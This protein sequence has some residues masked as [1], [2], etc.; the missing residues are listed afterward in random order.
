MK[1]TKSRVMCPD[2]RRQKMLFETEKE[3]KTFLKFN[4]EAVNPDGTREMR[5]YYCPACCGYH[6]SSHKFVG[7]NRRTDRMIEK[8]REE[9][10]GGIGAATELYEKLEAEKPTTRKAVNRWLK[11]QGY[12]NRAKDIARLRYYKEHKI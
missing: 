7:D 5:I 8:Y 12:S 3:A 11:E 2:C 1:P 4:E 9:T 10:D 6:I